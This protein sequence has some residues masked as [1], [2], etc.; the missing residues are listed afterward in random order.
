MSSIAPS[1]ATPHRLRPR[2]RRAEL[3]RRG[4]ALPRQSRRARHRARAGGRSPP[5]RRGSAASNSR[6]RC[7]LQRQGTG[8]HLR[9]RALAGAPRRE[10]LRRAQARMRARD[11]LPARPQCRGDPRAR[12]ARSWPRAT[13]SAITRYSHPLLSRMALGQGG[14]RDRPRHRRRRIR[15]LRQAPQR[16]D[17]A[18]LPL[19]RLCLQPGAARRCMQ[20]RGVSWCSAPTSGRA[21]GCR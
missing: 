17:D 4:R 13:A 9:R 1:R 20:K 5:A 19:S 6:R 10:I 15:A 18:V 7:R 14:G 8:A 12:P 16:A 21:T 3:E 11:I 2:V